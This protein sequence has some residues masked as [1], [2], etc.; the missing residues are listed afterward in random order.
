[1][2]SHYRSRS[3]F[4]A[5]KDLGELYIVSVIPEE[6]EIFKSQGVLSN[7][8]LD[9]HN[10]KIGGVEFKDARQY[11]QEFE[12][13][14]KL[15]IFNIAMMDRT[16]KNKGYEYIIEY[17]YLIVKKVEDF[18]LKNDIDIVF[19]EATWMH[20]IL[21]CEICKNL[22]IPVFNVQ[23]S[24]I[25]PNRFFFFKGYLNNS[26]YER[27][28]KGL[29]AKEIYKKVMLLDKNNKPQ[30]FDK[31]SNRN[32]FKL[33]KLIVLYDIIRLS[34]LGYSNKN[35]QPD[36]RKSLIRKIVSIIKAYILTKSNF[37]IANN[38]I[39]NLRYVLITLHVQPEASI[40]VLGS[41]FS[42]QI[43]FVQ[44]IARSTP[45]SH[46]VV[47]KEHP[48]AVGS[49]S[50]GF[51]KKLCENPNV[52]LAHPHEDSRE[53]IK[54]SDLVL[55]NTGTSSLEA[56]LAGVPSA[57]ASKMY[58][59]SILSTSIFNPC[60]D[61]VSSLIQNGSKWRCKVDREKVI[62]SLVDIEKNSFLGNLWEFKIDR[63]VLDGENIE[64]LR[65]AFK[66]VIDGVDA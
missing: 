14:L 29:N 25:I 36:W 15:N 53:L 20:E 6:R 64:N 56:A 10:P 43:G 11:I 28:V 44:D 38:K 18:I 22:S 47:V 16:I 37:F 7:S 60:T 19:L 58:F 5:I 9:L 31:L 21:T 27:K 54:K 48:H 52:I 8:I 59:S 12:I 40:D 2:E 62:H 45:S 23:I 4:K 55:S 46:M 41:K 30:Y 3:W 24:K 42:D 50:N 49:R 13:R 1:M 33:S 39:T 26:F 32:K 61:S 57:V 65:A 51:Y 63:S 66:E 34:V 17:A 35:V